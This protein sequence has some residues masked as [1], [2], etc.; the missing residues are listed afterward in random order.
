MTQVKACQTERIEERPERESESR[1][2]EN[3]TL[4]EKPIAKVSKPQTHPKAQTE[5]APRTE[6]PLL[7]A[8]S[9]QIVRDIVVSLRGLPGFFGERG[10]L[11]IC[12]SVLAEGEAAVS[13]I[14]TPRHTYSLFFNLQISK[15]WLC[16]KLILPETNQ[17]PILSLRTLFVPRNVILCL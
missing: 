13:S 11:P 5:G 16:Y 9:T 8:L 12:L 6:S 3:S 10:A 15:S 14:P 1:P 2:R 7:P 17:T 4:G